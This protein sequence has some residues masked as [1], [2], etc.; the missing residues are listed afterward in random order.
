ME[1]LISATLGQFEARATS[2]LPP[3]GWEQFI[4]SREYRLFIEGAY[5]CGFVCSDLRPNVDLNLINQHPDELG[6]FDL[7]RLRHYVHSMIRSER[8]SHG[9]GSFIWESTRSGALERLLDRLSN[10]EGLREPL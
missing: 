10:D 5:A 3:E 6:R 4:E 7:K 1:Q 9:Y 2:D 8:A